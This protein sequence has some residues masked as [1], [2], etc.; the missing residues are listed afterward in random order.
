MA[1]ARSVGQA[2]LKGL[3]SANI[4]GWQMISIV[5]SAG[6]GYRYQTMLSDVREYTGR[7]KYEPQVGKLNVNDVIPSGWMNKVDMEGP[8]KYKVW[9]D[10][11]YFDPVAN[12]YITDTRS[13]YADDLMRL[14]D[15]QTYFEDNLKGAGCRCDM[16]FMS[17]RVRSMD[18]NTNIP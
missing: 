10:V 7:L 12:E 6:Y 4:P 9:A 15:Y 8:Y 1:I 16:E 3:A 17:V 5:R 13:M 2:I 18:V 14:G 11:N